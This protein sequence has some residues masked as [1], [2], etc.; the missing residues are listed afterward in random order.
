MKPILLNTEMVRA[1]LEGRKRVT[2]RAIKPPALDK[3]V[4]DDA[5]DCVGSF[6]L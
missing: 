5:G 6:D 1:L 4:F 2:R 3:L